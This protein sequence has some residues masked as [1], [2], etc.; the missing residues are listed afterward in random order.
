MRSARTLAVALAAALLPSVA[1]ANSGLTPL[2]MAYPLALVGFVPIVLVEA[3]VLQRYAPL[4]YRPAF[5][6][7]VRVG[8]GHRLG[9]KGPHDR[10]GTPKKSQRDGFWCLFGAK[11]DQENDRFLG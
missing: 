1:L 8:L 11:I 2:V 5:R 6:L 4:Q 9:P 7:V 10:K 3:R